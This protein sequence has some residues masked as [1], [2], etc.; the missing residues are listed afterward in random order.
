MSVKEFLKKI[1]RVTRARGDYWADC[2]DQ[3]ATKHS[4]FRNTLR[5]IINEEI[6]SIASATLNEIEPHQEKEE[7]K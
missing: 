1:A 2:L 6:S 3:S 7:T 5:M 4:V